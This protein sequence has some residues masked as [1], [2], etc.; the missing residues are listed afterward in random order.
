MS[1]AQRSLAHARDA[2]ERGKALL[3]NLHTV[4]GIGITRRDGRYAVQ[5]SLAGPSLD[6]ASVPDEIAGVPVV[7]R[8]VGEVHKQ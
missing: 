1:D 2:K 4:A 5:V 8:V 7:V 3:A 6:S